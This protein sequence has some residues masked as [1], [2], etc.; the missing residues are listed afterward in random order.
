M[1]SCTLTGDDGET[2][3]V[4]VVSSEHDEA[5]GQVVYTVRLAD[6]TTTRATRD[7]LSDALNRRPPANGPLARWVSR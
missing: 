7:R 4:T 5:R 3:A 1:D 2:T 6:R